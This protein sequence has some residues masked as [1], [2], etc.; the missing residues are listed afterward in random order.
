MLYWYYCVDHSI[1][2]TV[3]LHS[4]ALYS[5]NLPTALFTIKKYFKFLVH[6]QKIK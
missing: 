3:C 5:I 4:N 2:I 1:N 6:F